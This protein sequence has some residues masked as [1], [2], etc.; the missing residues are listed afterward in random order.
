[1]KMTRVRVKTAVWAIV[2]RT[3]GSV[4]STVKATGP[5]LTPVS[6]RLCFI[7]SIAPLL[8]QSGWIDGIIPS[9]GTRQTLK[10][11]VAKNDNTVRKTMNDHGVCIGVSLVVLARTLSEFHCD[12]GG[13]GLLHSLCV[14]SDSC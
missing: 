1:M 2:L 11:S 6:K 5:Y 13:P 7:V 4:M 8:N 12:S 10:R 3:T 9:V 14:D